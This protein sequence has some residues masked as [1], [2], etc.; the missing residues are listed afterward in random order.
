[1]ASSVN[2]DEI[3]TIIKAIYEDD[4][5]TIIETMETM[6]EVE[7]STIIETIN[8][9]FDNVRNNARDCADKNQTFTDENI[10]AEWKKAKKT[11]KTL[12]VEEIF[13]TCCKVAII[14]MVIPAVFSNDY[15]FDGFMLR[16]CLNSFFG[17]VSERRLKNSA[18]V[19]LKW[20]INKLKPNSSTGGGKKKKRTKK[21][22]T[23][24]RKKRYTRYSSSQK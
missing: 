13:S 22:A 21:R 18:A 19:L 8:N 24:K 2:E 1:M 17:S 15:L 14:N 6:D 7:I 20:I 16:S 9:F 10:N 5:D 4:I 12:G 23:K 3:D 11:L